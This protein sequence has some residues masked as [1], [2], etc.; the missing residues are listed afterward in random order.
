MEKKYPII[1][2]IVLCSML[3]SNTL[4]NGFALDDRAVITENSLTKMGLRGIGDLITH[5]HFYGYSHTPTGLYR[6]I[7]LVTHAIEYEV[8]GLSPFTGHLVNLF[9]YILA[10]ISLFYAL[11]YWFPDR[12]PLLPLVAVILFAVHPLHTEV[13]ANIKGR[14]ELITL[15]FLSIS[16]IFSFR[17]ARRST[18]PDYLIGVLFFTLALFSKE[19][20]LTFLVIIPISLWFFGKTTLKK[21]L[22]VFAGLAAVAM[23]YLLIRSHFAD[24]SGGFRFL[25]G[26]HQYST[27]R[28]ERLATSTSAL[29]DYLKLLV[30]PYPLVYDYSYNHIQAVSWVNPKTVISLIIHLSLMIFALVTLPRKHFLSFCILTYFITLSVYANIITPTSAVFA[31]R[32]LFIPSIAFSIAFSWMLFKLLNIPDDS[33]LPFQKLPKTRRFIFLMTLCAIVLCS[34]ILTVIRNRA[35]KDD[36]TLFTTDL[37]HLEDNARAHYNVATWYSRKA[38]ADPSRSDSTCSAEAIRYFYQTVAI[39]P[40]FTEAWS[41]AGVLLNNRHHYPEAIVAF[42][43]AEESANASTLPQNSLERDRRYEGKAW[44]S[45]G[46]QT[47]NKKDF[48]VSANCFRNSA[49]LD[50]SNPDAMLNIGACYY[51]LN[52]Y[53]SAAIYYQKTLQ[54]NPRATYALDGLG[55]IALSRKKIVDAIGFFRKAVETDPAIAERYR[56]MGINLK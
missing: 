16:V 42:K 10:C 31:E 3:Y 46:L 27:V 24:S 7:P 23:L 47:F 49:N 51:N 30:F 33:R 44:F 18:I 8:A 32:F 50:P 55:S 17:Y 15:L 11:S 56:E 38:L 12:N 48:A 45:L 19:S 41:M 14:D 1:L 35:W 6:P 37:V 20:A 25:D 4:F 29:L 5:D 22:V 21:I 26:Y 34:G 40:G 53:D 39:D 13:V 54:I 43:K 9:L 36:F 52:Q 28:A 2:I